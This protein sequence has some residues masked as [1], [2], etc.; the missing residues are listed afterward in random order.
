MF[1]RTP[2]S[3]FTDLPDF[4]YKPN[5]VDLPSSNGLRLAFIDEKT[6]NYIDKKSNVFLCLHGVPTYSFLYR[7]IIP[8]LL[9][10]NE[11]HNN[12]IRVI[13]PDFIGFGRSDKPTQ[14]NSSIHNLEFH[15]NSII[16]LI[17]H[18]Q[19]TNI[20]LIVQD[21]G[22]LIGATLPMSINSN[23]KQI[24]NRIILFNTFICDGSNISEGFLNWRNYS[25]NLNKKLNAGR[26]IN[27]S[28]RDKEKGLKY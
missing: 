7:K 21:W 2:E 19:L 20:T 1:V 13:C 14:N 25:T 6:N 27:S 9:K 5:Y 17:S 22:G 15:R 18:L 28:V 24:I 10:S 23:N 26:I 11:S 4:P 3:R 16:F 8:V 12:G